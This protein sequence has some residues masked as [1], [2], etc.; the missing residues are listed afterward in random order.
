MGIESL[1][2]AGFFYRGF[3]VLSHL[4]DGDEPCHAVGGD[5]HGLELHIVFT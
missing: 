5:S 4:V 1:R 2:I 3:G